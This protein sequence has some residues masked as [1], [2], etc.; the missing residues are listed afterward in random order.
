MS[1]KSEK[2]TTVKCGERILVTSLDAT[3]DVK[4]LQNFLDFLFIKDRLEE[5]PDWVRQMDFFDDCEQK[6]L[7]EK[8][9][10]EIK[11]TKAN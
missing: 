7:V 6:G 3:S 2:I 5:I 9:R 1:N 8:E 10:N 4:K 11:S